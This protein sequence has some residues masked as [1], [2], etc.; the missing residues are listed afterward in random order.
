MNCLGAEIYDLGDEFL[1]LHGF[2]R[3]W[4]IKVLIRF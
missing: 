1:Q 2:H 3:L 4:I